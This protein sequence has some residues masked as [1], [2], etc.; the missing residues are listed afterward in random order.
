MIALTLFSRH[1]YLGAESA[2]E[3]D[4]DRSTSD[5]DDQRALL[6]PQ[7][8]RNE[9]N[10]SGYAVRIAL[11]EA[12]ISPMK[13]GEVIQN[14]EERLCEEHEERDEVDDDD[15]ERAEKDETEKEEDVIA[16][17][18]AF[19]AAEA[20]KL[21]KINLLS[22]CRRLFALGVE[23]FRA[24]PS[25]E[26]AKRMR[27]DD[28]K[29]FKDI[30]IRH[31][32]VSTGE[33]ID[34]APKPK[35]TR[36]LVTSDPITSGTSKCSFAKE[37]LDEKSME[38]LKR[39]IQRLM[40]R[41]DIM[42]DQ[43]DADW[44]EKASLDELKDTLNAYIHDY[45]YFQKCHPCRNTWYKYKFKNED[46]P[47]L[48]GYHERKCTLDEDKKQRGMYTNKFSAWAD[49]HDGAPQP[50]QIFE[51]MI[52]NLVHLAVEHTNNNIERYRQD[53]REEQEAKDD[54]K[55]LAD[56]WIGWQKKDKNGKRMKCSKR[57]QKAWKRKRDDEDDARL[58]DEEDIRK[59]IACQLWLGV[60]HK[61]S[62]A[63]SWRK[64][65]GD[66]FLKQLM[67]FERYKHIDCF[68]SVSCPPVGEGDEP[69][70]MGKIYPFSKAMHQAW[71]S[72]Y[73]PGMT[74]AIDEQTY[75]FRG[76][77]PFGSWRN[78]SKRIGDGPQCFAPAC[79]GYTFFSFW[80]FDKENVAHESTRNFFEIDE[81]QTSIKTMVLSIMSKLHNHLN[82]SGNGAAKWRCVVLDNLFTSVDLAEK[83]LDLKW[84]M[85]GTCRQ[86]G[87]NYP[88][89]SECIRT[90]DDDDDNEHYR[91]PRNTDKRWSHGWD[92]APAAGGERWV[93]LKSGEYKLL[94]LY[95]KEE[96]KPF[97][98]P[99]VS[100]LSKIQVT[101]INAMDPKDRVHCAMNE[102]GVTMQSDYDVSKKKPSVFN[103][104]STH[105]MPH[106]EQQFELPKHSRRSFFERHVNRTPNAVF[107]NNKMGG[108]DIADQLSLEYSR[109]QRH[110]FKK[111][112]R[113]ILLWYLDTARVNAWLLHQSYYDTRG[114][115]AK[116]T[117]N[118][119]NKHARKMTHAQFIEAICHKLVEKRSVVMETRTSKKRKTETEST[120]AAVISPTKF[121]TSAQKIALET[122]M[123]N[124][125]DR[126]GTIDFKNHCWNLLAKKSSTCG[127]DQ[128]AY[129]R[130]NCV[131][132]KICCP[133][134]TNERPKALY[135]C[136]ACPGISFC[137]ECLKIFHDKNMK[138]T[139][140]EVY[141]KTT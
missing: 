140:A 24:T 18:S 76:R 89:N 60:H 98:Y 118:H 56:D 107:Y 109:V 96:G 6:S 91:D 134:D 50:H 34:E 126:R 105:S 127:S 25:V 22:E 85:H 45:E 73:K 49:T 58:F 137:F 138:R 14:R 90:C 11:V 9:E 29:K 128:N 31:I 83:L 75:P 79:D 21:T 16:L 101:K 43:C 19:N 113:V 92:R 82:N 117:S 33:R 68:F 28:W 81:H 124:H 47:N 53:L 63:A 59:Y 72:N 106:E 119:A 27:E 8:R 5:E 4:D 136:T 66:P 129:I 88:D 2:S 13:I 30:L 32:N 57:K 130:V 123:S 36:A 10:I 114:Q 62:V 7:G 55:T 104:I 99:K 111:W 93:K 44:K 48:N 100:N 86:N 20:K 97:L 94:T 51:R 41:G 42:K 108:V 103:M 65:Y 38:L 1:F 87:M 80:K 125:D 23:A 46:V 120:T 40:D 115:R 121:D 135:S 112:N 17:R 116:D 122:I 37:E 74:I 77:H 141:Y 69:Q 26:D 61:I 78:R 54:G 12:Q 132:H 84:T 102:K 35:P 15:E 139:V 133:N 67:T 3:A 39:E 52:G 71:L 70:E 131:V 110:R 95:A 64:L